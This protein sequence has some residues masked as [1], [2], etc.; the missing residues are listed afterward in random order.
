[1]LRVGACIALVLAA[2]GDADPCTAAGLRELLSGARAG[3]EVELGSCRVRGSFDVPAGVRVTGQGNASVI[4][5]D[6]SGPALRLATSTGG[7]TTLSSARI[8]SASGPA[9]VGN[10]PGAIEIVSVEVEITTGLGIGLRGVT[11][12]RIS[13]VT[14]RGPVTA[15]NAN[16]VPSNAGLDTGTVGLALVDVAT[17]AA[18]FSLER[19]GLA[20]F[21]PW[22]AI[23]ENAHVRWSG[24]SVDACLGTAVFANGG[25]LVFDSVAIRE[26]FQ[27]IQPW[28]ATGGAF[29]GTADVTTTGF[30]IERSEGIGVLHAGS[31]GDHTDVVARDN[32]FGGI[33]VQ[34]SPAFAIQGTSMLEGNG[35]A[36]L[37]LVAS[38]G[39]TVS[40]AT[41][42][43]THEELA[44]FGELA[45]VRTGDGIHLI[46]TS[47]ATLSGV[48]L[49]NNA[50][51]GVLVDVG[52]APIHGIAITGTTVTGEGTS[53]GA[54]AQASGA[55]VPSGTWDAGITRMGATVTNDAAASMALATT[56]EV[57]SSNVP[58][59]PT[60]LLSGVLSP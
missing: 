33:W 18:P 32:R 13:D 4:E 9:L 42:A 24:G 3:D 26:V 35:L 50:R 10:G 39:A 60:D 36:A 58:I 2:C 46:D 21:G 44:L 54:I 45:A 55:L 19:V 12:G 17:V 7:T 1:M 6:G 49:T 47:R 52:A 28:A 34:E 31:S 41:I 11:A 15:S 29:V 5:S 30:T 14:L 43:T 8:V 16:S 48:T 20:G 27:G 38:D 23:V 57:S 53:L 25:S 40:G 51:I 56:G 59:I 37:A 22:G